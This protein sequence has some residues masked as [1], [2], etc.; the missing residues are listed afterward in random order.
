MFELTL[1]SSFFVCFVFLFS[2]I[3]HFLIFSLFCCESISERPFI[4][5][6]DSR[7]TSKNINN[8]FFILNTP[9]YMI[10]WSFPTLILIIEGPL[11]YYMNLFLYI[12]KLSGESISKIT[13]VRKTKT[14]V[15]ILMLH[16]QKQEN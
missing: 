5:S 8:V 10:S 14:N 1:Y 16:L 2:V 3:L 15:I 6:T 12:F 9:C 7:F 13:T 11:K 4:F